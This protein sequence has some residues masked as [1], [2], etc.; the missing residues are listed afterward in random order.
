LIRVLERLGE[1]HS[2]LAS[3]IYQFLTNITKSVG[4]GDK[5][6]YLVENFTPLVSK[7]TTIPT[8]YL[9]Q[10]FKNIPLSHAEFLLVCESIEINKSPQT[11]ISVGLHLKGM[12][13]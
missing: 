13:L 11:L 7:F 12:F 10:H 3:K 6:D 5:R 2:V 1:G 9:I 8:E 4:P